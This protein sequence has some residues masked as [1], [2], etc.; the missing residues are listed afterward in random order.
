MRRSRWM[1]RRG[2][3]RI[4]RYWFVNRLYF[5]A[6]PTGLR[7]ELLES[8]YPPLKRGANKHCAS[9]AIV[10]LNKALIYIASVRQRLKPGPVEIGGDDGLTP[11]A[12]DDAA[13]AEEGA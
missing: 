10:V 8:I 6:V 5:C 9:G 7:N 12:A 3:K 2:S 11:Q 1:D 4:W 13:D